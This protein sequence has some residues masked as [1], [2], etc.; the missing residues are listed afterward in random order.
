M[1]NPVAAFYDESPLCLTLD[2]L[3]D[4]LEAHEAFTLLVPE[5]N[6][7]KFL[8]A[9][10]PDKDTYGPADFPRVTI[11]PVSINPNVEGA[12]GKTTMRVRWEARILTGTQRLDQEM[13]PVIFAIYAAFDD[14][15]NQIVPGVTWKTLN[16][17]KNCRQVEVVLTNE[18]DPGL[19]LDGWVGVWAGETDLWFKSTDLAY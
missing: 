3:W 4:M 6:R 2:A 1:A 9:P 18:S 11:V 7:V 17:I 15:Q 8:S 5:N 12:S 14:W 16:P 10:M 13:L 19:L